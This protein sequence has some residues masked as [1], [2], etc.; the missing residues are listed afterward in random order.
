MLSS[1]YS[2]LEFRNA[3]ETLDARG[4]RNTQDIRRN[5][6][7]D[8]QKELI[9]AN[10]DVVKDFGQVAA[11][12]RTVGNALATLQS[13]C[14]SLRA[15]VSAARVETAPM[16]DE[17]AGL[18][19]QKQRT[20]TK[21][22]VLVAFSEHYLMSEAE[23]ATLISTAEPVDDTFF[24][25]L[26]KAKR[27]QRDSQLLLSGENQRLGLDVLDRTRR[28]LDAGFQKL[29]RWTQR[30]FRALDLENPSVS[31][32]VRRALRVLAERPQLFQ[33]CLDSFAE[34]RERDLQT[35]F[36]TALTGGENVTNSQKPI[37]FSAHEPLRYAGD[38]L[39]WA[40]ATTVSERE[41]LEVL[42][43]SGSEEIAAS[44]KEGLE[45]GE[46][47]LRRDG[48]DRPFD[49]RTALAQLVD[50][51]LAGVAHLLSLRIG[52]ILKGNGDTVLH[53]RIA[54]L[55]EFYHTIF[56]RLLLP[57][58]TFLEKLRTIKTSALT[59]FQTAI[60]TA[61][62]TLSTE[63]ASAP[64]PLDDLDPPDFLEDALES[65]GTLLQN[66]ETS[67]APTDTDGAGLTLLLTT[68]LNPY[69]DICRAMS[70]LL[71]RPKG[72]VFAANCLMATKAAL[73][74]GGSQAS[75][76]D[77]IIALDATLK[78]VEQSMTESQYEYL[79]EQS[80][81]DALLQA[82]PA[83]ADPAT[84]A[85]GKAKQA[86]SAE[87]NGADAAEDGHAE[88]KARDAHLDACVATARKA[89]VFQPSSLTRVSARLDAFLPSALMDA[90]ERLAGCSSRSLVHTAT[91]A[92]ANRFC[93]AFETI[94][95]IVAT[96][97]GEDSEVRMQVWPRSG[98]EVRVLL[99]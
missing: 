16:L 22:R 43:V 13:H 34:A 96:L 49:G 75:T 45:A 17:A 26:L 64:P 68:A 65:L 25:A 39:A 14:A 52:Q 57:E 30:E 85:S 54:C 6:R 24:A 98:E 20:E 89:A 53:Y 69:L 2:D 21:K 18:L 77:R 59:H 60:E 7:L 79:T 97:V 8:V 36:H 27:I 95:E 40:H 19:S 23:Q 41:A 10:G 61:A 66:Y 86:A 80:G 11:Q 37:D 46:P 99:S 48:D 12:L 70:A 15:H 84:T 78:S 42:F 90:R 47:W 93:D 91:D 92:A 4:I 33:Q 72:D 67:V 88:D 56:T 71:P 31:S 87:T 51:D 35:S 29:F 3:L 28:S 44:I 58:A 82:L 9:D 81:L 5:L 38:M 50:R 94:E 1:S 63:H 55:S 74:A 73:L 83:E 32:S 76:K 62:E